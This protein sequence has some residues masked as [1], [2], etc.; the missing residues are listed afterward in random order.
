MDETYGRKVVEEL[1]LA[2]TTREIT[3]ARTGDIGHGSNSKCGWIGKEI[4][5]A[6]GSDAKWRES[7]SNEDFN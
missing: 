7:G 4:Y 3:V 6:C 5:V 2:H 1:V